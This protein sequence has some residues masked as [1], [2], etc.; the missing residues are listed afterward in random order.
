MI[1]VLSCTIIFAACKQKEVKEPGMLATPEGLRVEDEVLRW[2]AVE[3]AE[4]YVVEIDEEQFEVTENYLDVFSVFCKS[5][6]YQI[7]VWAW[8]KQNGAASSLLAEMTY[9]PQLVRSYALHE[10]QGG[11]E[12]EIAGVSPEKI[13]GKAVIPEKNEKDGKPITQISA[14]AFKNC[15]ELTGVVIGAN[16]KVIANNAFSGC[17]QLQRVVLP[18]TVE[19]IGK[20]AFA[21]CTALS[22]INLPQGVSQIGWRAFYRCSSLREIVLPEELQKI[23]SGVFNG[24]T[25]LSKINLPQGVSQIG[26]SAF[27]WCSSLREIVL[28]KELQKIESGVFSGCTALSAITIPHRVKSI[29]PMAFSGCDQLSRLEVESGNPVYRSEGNCVIRKSDQALIVGVATSVIPDTVKVIE[30]RAFYGCSALVTMEIPGSV[31]T[32]MD[33]AFVGCENLRSLSFC[34]GV[35]NFGNPKAK[36]NTSIIA[37]C[38]SLTALDLP[39][40]I[41]YIGSAI[42]DTCK[43]LK[44]LTVAPG[45]PIFRSEG[46]CIIRISDGEV[47]QGSSISVIPSGVKRIG[48]YAF[49]GYPSDVI[50]IPT[51]VESIGPYAFT[52]SMLTRLDLPD[53]VKSIGI[54]AFHAPVETDIFSSSPFFDNTISHSR[55]VEVH[56]SENLLYVGEGAFKYC[57]LLDCLSIPSSVIEIRKEAFWGCGRLTL[58]LP[59]SVEKIGVNAFNG[60]TVYTDALY[61]QIP[62]GWETNVSDAGTNSKVSWD[63]GCKLI[64]GC[65]FQKDENGPYVSSFTYQSIPWNI[66]VPR[67]AGYTFM[68]WATEPDSDVVVYGVTQHFAE[69]GSIEKETAFSL[70]DL[71]K[72]EVGTIFYAVWRANEA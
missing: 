33:S 36:N 23:E 22:K 56:L 24:C 51:G 46:N 5:K 62:T 42:F 67:R 59:S 34:E 54:E 16:V 21:D 29:D 70:E 63:S 66:R 61:D 15:T 2:D 57:Q 30:A 20:S 37:G 41:E 13:A 43:N 25:A 4:G 52:Q 35:K 18:D 1:V 27:S 17:T 9:R 26:T 49:S 65:V 10:I 39:A 6:T 40:S 72:M 64:C 71:Q 50:E 32:V 44:N 48:A 19:Q 12:Y 45:S 60:A 28:P 53:T 69:D 68:G 3:N 14:A 58:I 38:E 31:E 11:K 7:K 47:V 8:G 55:L